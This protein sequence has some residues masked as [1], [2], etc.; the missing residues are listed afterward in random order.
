MNLL[1][2]NAAQIVTCKGS[3]LPKSGNSQSDIGLIENGSIFISNGKIEFAGNSRDF[4]NFANSNGIGDVH[5]IDARNKVIMPGFVDSHTHFV[6][7]GSRENEYEMRQAGKSYQEIAES[8]GGIR[9]TV[10]RVRESDFEEL[11][12]S[13]FEKLSKFFSYGTTAIEGKSGYGLDS[14]NEMKML[15]VLNS[16]NS[17]NEFGMDVIATFLGA[18]SIPDELGKDEYTDLICNEIIPEVSKKNLS[19][20]IDIF[21]EENYF[22]SSDADRILSTGVKHGLIPRTHIDQ[23]TSMG[24]TEVSLKHGAVSLDHLEAMIDED[25]NRLAS[26]NSNAKRK[27][28]AGLLP[29]VSYFLG[30]AYAPARKLIEAGVPVLIAT[31]FNPGSCMSENLQLM[32]SLAST[33]MKMTAEEIINAVTINPAYSLGLENLIGSI[34]KGKQADLLMF[35]MPSYKYLIYNFG[36]NNLEYVIKK[37]RLFKMNDISQV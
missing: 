10:K 20:Y 36:V 24:G 35:D 13:A 14:R 16:L 3:S 37:G 15:E 23:F 21:I 33:Q 25:V 27:T 4:D 22:N 28:L 17:S 18:H 26:H 5:E 31:D 9:S 6:F 34:E 8:G 1:I 32:M 30:I 19:R 12:K 2:K 11:R 7:A 29:G